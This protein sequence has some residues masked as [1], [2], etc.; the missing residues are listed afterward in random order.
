M[1][2]YLWQNTGKLLG[3]LIGCNAI[4]T[5]FVNSASA[6]IVP[7]NT[8][9]NEA[10]QLLNVP[11]FPVQV[12]EGGAVRGTNLFHSF[13]QFNVRGGEGAYFANPAGIQNILS[14]VT[15]TEPSRILG[16]LGVSGNANLFLINPNGI[17]FG[18]NAR[19]DVKG[20][21]VGTTANSV[22]F[23]DGL[24]FSATDIQDSSL[25][26][27][28][29][30]IGLQFGSQP[31]SITNQAVNG[32]IIGSSRTLA[33]VGGEITLDNGILFAPNGQI[34]L[35]AV[36]GDTTFGLDINGSSVGFELSENLRR[37]PINLTNGS[38]IVTNGNSA[39]E[40]FGG[41]IGLEGSTIA[42]LGG[43]IWVDATQF[44]LNNGSSIQ[45]ITSRA[46]NGGDIQIQASDAVT[47]TNGSLISS[48][49]NNSATGGDVTIN[50]KKITVAGDGIPEN[51]GL[52][53]VITSS[54][55]NGGNLNLNATES[56]NINGGFVSVVSG[57]C[58]VKR[59]S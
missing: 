41:Q 46:A 26:S 40:L 57:G 58:A 36:G 14:R 16:L 15:G 28:N 51:S 11:G 33:L 23:P 1:T 35:A 17:V 49:S 21:F 4:I 5:G 29:I 25:L 54:S 50:S 47:V 39:I 53:A 34:K 7:D 9:G 45:S 8:L 19:L 20:A 12:I 31:G 27:I 24:Q 6:Q 22:L 59:C 42:S 18:P 10:S 56:V 38:F 44:N 43:S 48:T 55:G 13:S 37:A 32:L 3:F 2:D 30:P 52:I